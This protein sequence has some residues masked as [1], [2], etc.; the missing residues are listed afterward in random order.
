MAYV[1]RPF[2]V[3]NIVSQNWDGV[4]DIINLIVTDSTKKSSIRL[5][6]A[7]YQQESSIWKGKRMEKQTDSHLYTQGTH[8]K[9]E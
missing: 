6:T 4:I 1:F 8:T 7:S 5:K 2:L 3:L 9:K